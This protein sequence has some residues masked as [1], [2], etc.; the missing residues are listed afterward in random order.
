MNTQFSVLHL[1]PSEIPTP[2]CNSPNY[3]NLSF[4]FHIVAAG[5]GA[6]AAV[7][8]PL[9]GDGSGPLVQLVFGTPDAGPPPRPGNNIVGRAPG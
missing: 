9:A 4:S 6:V 7:G 8:R 1:T 3:W 5:A 2:S